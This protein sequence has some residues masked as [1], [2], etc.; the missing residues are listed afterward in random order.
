LTSFDLDLRFLA[1]KT[2]QRFVKNCDCKIAH[3][4]MGRMTCQ[5]LRSRL[6]QLER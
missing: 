3:K 4:E 6:Q 1:P 2:V 5:I